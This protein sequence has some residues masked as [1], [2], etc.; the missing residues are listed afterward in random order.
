MTEQNTRKSIESLLWYDSRE[1]QKFATDQK[2]LRQYLEEE[3]AKKISQYQQEYVELKPKAKKRFTGVVKPWWQDFRESGFYEELIE[4]LRTNSNI[5][6]LSLSDEIVYPWPTSILEQQ[7]NANPFDEAAR[8]ILQEKKKKNHYGASRLEREHLP[9]NE[10]WQARFGLSISG[11]SEEFY[12]SRWPSREKDY[13]NNPPN[14]YSKTSIQLNPAKE[15]QWLPKIHPKV[16]LGLA[17]QIESG[18]TWEVLHE[19]LT[20]FRKEKEFPPAKIIFLK[21]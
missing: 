1:T 14:W 9:E 7:S 5:S 15:N 17:D 12:I 16:W 6:G 4:W 2:T 11:Q 20:W 18:R 21:D 3:A 10:L 19:S 13:D 8:L